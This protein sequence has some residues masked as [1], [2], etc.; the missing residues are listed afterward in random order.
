MSQLGFFFD[1]NKCTG[2][3]CCQIACKDRNDLPVGLLYRTVKSYETGAFPN[4]RLF[5]YPHTCNHCAS[6]ACVA[7]CPTGAMMKADD[8]TVIHDDATCIGCGTCAQSC[9]Y[10][11]PTIDEETKTAGKCDS[12][13]SLRD[14]GMNPVCVDAC[15]MRC[16]EFG[17]LEELR[18]KHGADEVTNLLPFLPSPEKTQPSLIVKPKPYLTESSA[19]VEIFF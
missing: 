17:D 7:N 2:C 14:A 4:P 13:K 19:I 1:M 12:C 16:I 11:I 15:M 10:A 6:P 3:H 9:P 18:K 8:G 5:H